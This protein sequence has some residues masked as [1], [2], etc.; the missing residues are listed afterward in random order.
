M[1]T[2]LTILFWISVFTGG[3][4]ILLLLLSL[5]GGMD[6]D[7]D[8]DI[9][10]DSDMDSG[11]GLGVVKGVLTF[12]SV[13]TWV[14]RI[15][16]IYEQSTPVSITVGILVGITIVYLLSKLLGFLMS[17]TEF[18]TYSIE[19]TLNKIGKVYLKIPSD[20]EGIVQVIVNDS[21]KDFKGK[22]HDNTEIPTGTSVRVMDVDKGY[23]IVK[24]E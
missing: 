11:G 6:F 21:M 18:N 16:L 12:I 22:S 9:G 2:I 19:D 1:M 23:V 4:M 24:P 13:S 8:L 15:L 7:L 20:G 14:V 10:G 3:I 5:I 17:Q